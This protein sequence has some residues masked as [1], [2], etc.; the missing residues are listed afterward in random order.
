MLRTFPNLP[1]RLLRIDSIYLQGIL[2]TIYAYMW[3]YICPCAELIKHYA[4]K[5]HGGV[6]LQIHIVLT[7]A[8]AGGEWSA[9]R[10]A[11]L[12]PGERAP[13]YRLNRRLDEPQSRS[14]RHGE[15]KILD[16][17]G[18]RTSTPRSSSPQ[19]VA[20]PTALTRL[21][22]AYKYDF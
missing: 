20:I 15:E 21:L 22:C 5:A 2:N 4:M 7:T 12:T 19:P 8:V 17:T 11:C 1:Q 10:P 6:D 9:S 18:T 3:R 13:R 16:P 14:G